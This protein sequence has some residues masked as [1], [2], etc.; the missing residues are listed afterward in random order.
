MNMSKSFNIWLGRN[1]TLFGR[2][3]VSKTHGLSHLIYSLTM[4]ESN[5]SICQSA[6]KE[7]TQYIW[8]YKPPN[9]KHSTIIEKIEQGGW[10]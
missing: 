2:I 8:G 3:L 9:V 10:S 7:I 4:T 5:I 1:L 6:Q